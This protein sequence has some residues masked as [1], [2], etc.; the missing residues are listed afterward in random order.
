[1]RPSRVSSSCSLPMG[2]YAEAKT[3]VVAE[4]M[5]RAEA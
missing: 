1:M 4:I 3:D 2:D 5:R